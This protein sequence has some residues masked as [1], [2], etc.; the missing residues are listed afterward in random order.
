V[1]AFRKVVQ[2]TGPLLYSSK[3]I[4][5]GKPTR[6]KKHAHDN[7]RLRTYPLTSQPAKKQ[8]Q[9]SQTQHPPSHLNLNL[10]RPM[11][12]KLGSLLAPPPKLDKPPPP[13]RLG[14]FPRPTQ[15][16][17]KRRNRQ[18]VCQLLPC[19]G[20]TVV[21][22]PPPL[23]P[24]SPLSPLP[25]PREERPEP[26]PRE[27]RPPPPREERPDPPPREESPLPPP[28]E[29]RPLPPPRELSPP[30]PLEPLLLPLEPPRPLKPLSPLR[31]EPPP[32][33]ERPPRP[34]LEEVVSGWSHG[35][36]M[37]ADC[38]AVRNEEK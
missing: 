3:C 38:A 8:I 27:E 12:P 7:P 24:L 26:P 36:Q 35:F 9:P 2:V 10:Q 30:R 25:L 37:L 4:E 28:R 11:P 5:K 19:G 17:R 20:A 23:S 16:K 13:P 22:L 32:S 14:S 18:L 21:Y 6:L 15:R 33:E 34:P 31:P 29:E 1:K